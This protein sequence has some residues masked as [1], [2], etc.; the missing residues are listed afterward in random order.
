[1]SWRIAA[2]SAVGTSH[3]LTGLPCQDSFG[4]ELVD[5]SHGAVLVSV[6]SDG[7][8]S[9]AHSERGS[10]VAVETSLHL[11]RGYLNAGGTVSSIQRDLAVSWVSEIQRVITELTEQADSTA[12]EFACTLLVAIIGSDSAAFVQIGDGAM[13]TANEAEG[14]WSY[15]FWPQHGEFANTTN[16]V[17]SPHSTEIMDFELADRRID[18]FAS[19]SDGIENL[20]LH[21]STKSVHA[22][23][24]TS[25]L[26]PVQQLARPGLDN[27]LSESLA[28][29]LSSPRVCERTDDDKSLVLASRASCLVDTAADASPS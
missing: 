2:A 7:A 10:K 23:F 19:F 20:V 1:M 24:F 5:T 22:P 29:Y 27:P 8:G 26:G 11:I 12:R 16:F 17:T 6:V 15:I 21:H 4:V 14:G 28:K 13:V 18:N 9:A 3:E 25:M